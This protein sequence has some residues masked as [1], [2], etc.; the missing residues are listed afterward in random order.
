MVLILC[1][2]VT[3]ADRYKRRSQRGVT[4]KAVEDYKSGAR[5]F[6]HCENTHG[7]SGVRGALVA[8]LFLNFG[9]T[10]IVRIQTVT[11][12]AARVRSRERPWK[13]T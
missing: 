1:N 8:I 7:E 12:G 6:C 10:G 4:E 2:Y 3:L 13:T 11:S 5:K 9:F